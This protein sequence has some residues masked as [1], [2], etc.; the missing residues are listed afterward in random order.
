MK[1]T[2]ILLLLGCAV[3]LSGCTK[4]QIVAPEDG[5]R[6]VDKPDFEAKAD[7]Q[8]DWEQIGEDIDSIYTDEGSYPMCSGEDA[9]NFDIDPE[10]KTVQIN[11]FVKEETTKEDA[12]AYANAVLKGMNDEIAV[13]DFSVEKSSDTSYGGYYKDKTVTITVIAGNPMSGEENYLVD[14]TIEP[15]TD[16]PIQAK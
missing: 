10:G 16:T 12:V 7:V 14:Q 1:I 9:V 5:T 11:L 3:L 6:A 2:K 13:Q 8:L 15:G 4:S